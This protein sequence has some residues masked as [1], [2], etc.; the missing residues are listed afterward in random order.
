MSHVCVGGRL[1]IHARSTQLINM[2][3]F[4]QCP[5]SVK[6]VHA[7]M[8]ERAFP[9]PNGEPKWNTSRNALVSHTTSDLIIFMKRFMV[10][11]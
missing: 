2:I 4:Q 7:C 6:N 1:N 10:Q 9:E 3:C 11:F 8:H 5:G